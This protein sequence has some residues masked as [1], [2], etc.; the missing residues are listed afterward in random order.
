MAL[1]LLLFLCLVNLHRES[2]T[3]L[4]GDVPFWKLTKT[5]RD[6]KQARVV[7]YYFQCDNLDQNHVRIVSIYPT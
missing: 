6:V 4:V 5:A 2:Q 3:A 7:L 1:L